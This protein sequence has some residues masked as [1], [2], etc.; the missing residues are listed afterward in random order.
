[1]V[2]ISSNRILINESKDDSN[3]VNSTSQTFTV[4]PLCK[5]DNAIITDPESGEIVCS[6]CGMVKNEVS[7]GYS[8]D[9]QCDFT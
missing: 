8:K 5:S 7:N 9:S 6:Q 2:I 3:N 1:M 4:C